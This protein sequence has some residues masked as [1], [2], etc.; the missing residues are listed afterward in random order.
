MNFKK[1][2]S[3]AALMPLWAVQTPA[4][5]ENIMSREHPV[6]AGDTT[7]VIKQPEKVT[8]TKTA[9]NM[10]VKVE[11]RKDNASY[12][13]SYSTT[14]GDDNTYTVSETKDAI[15]LALPFQKF[16][17]T[18]SFP[19]FLIGTSNAVNSAPGIS[20]PFG[21]GLEIGFYPFD[22]RGPKLGNHWNLNLIF[23]FLWRNYRMTGNNRFYKTGN[24]VVITSY[25]EGSDVQFSRVKTFSLQVPLCLTW[26]A[27]VP[28]YRLNA[29]IGPIFSWNTYASIKTR[30]KIDGKKHKDVDKNVHQTPLTIDLYGGFS[31]NDIGLYVRWSPFNVL[32]TDNAPRFN[33]LSCGITL[34]L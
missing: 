3:L 13:Y 25:P 9:R 18:G 14:L 22:I 2:I 7:V 31:I 24:Q 5:T 21:A 1:I 8:I 23:G 34:D 27:K 30:Y 29:N 15:G 19:L 17:A 32:Q 4:A 33:C 12:R 28:H 11:G 20:T 26:H 6:Q 16:D 10:S